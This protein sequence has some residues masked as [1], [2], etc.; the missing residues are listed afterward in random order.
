MVGGSV[1]LRQQ[2]ATAQFVMSDEVV[3]GDLLV[4][5]AGGVDVHASVAQ[6]GDGRFQLED[7]TGVGLLVNGASMK[8]RILEDTGHLHAGALH[9]G[10]HGP[11]GGALGHRQRPG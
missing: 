3:S 5:R 2:L 4:A 1:V 10:V 7:H 11:A 8:T 6:L 9:G